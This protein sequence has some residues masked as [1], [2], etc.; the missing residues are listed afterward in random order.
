MPR[1]ARKDVLAFLE[2]FLAGKG[3]L[4]GKGQFG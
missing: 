2:R 3:Q 4:E 1:K